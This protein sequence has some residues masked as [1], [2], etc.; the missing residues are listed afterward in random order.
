ME[1]F[2]YMGFLGKIDLKNSE[3]VLGC[4]EECGQSIMQQNHT[5][6]IGFQDH[7]R[8]RV[9]RT[10]HEGDGEYRQLYFGRLVRCFPS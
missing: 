2:A 6:L 3:I 7:D 9:T 4:F 8:S 10:R 5:L 1:S